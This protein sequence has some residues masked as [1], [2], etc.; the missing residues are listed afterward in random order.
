VVLFN[1]AVVDRHARVID[2]FV[3]YAE[4]IGLRRPLE[5]IDRLR[6][7]ALSS[8][9]NLEYCMTSRGFGSVISSL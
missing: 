4:R 6:P 2:G 8:G 7:V 5:V 3:N 9:V 1:G